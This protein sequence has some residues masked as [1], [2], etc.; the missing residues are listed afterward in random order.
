MDSGGWGLIQSNPGDNWYG[1]ANPKY[2][3]LAQYT[4]HIR[5]GMNIINSTGIN[6]V[7]AYD[8]VGRKLVIVTMNYGTAQTI[9]YNQTNFHKASGPVRCWT[10]SP[11][12]DLAR[13]GALYQESSGIVISNQTFSVSFPTNTIKTF[14]IQN[15]ENATVTLANLTRTYTGSAISASASTVP[16]GLTVNPIYNGSPTAPTNVGS[17]IV[18]GTIG[19][20]NYSGSATNTLAISPAQVAVSCR[21]TNGIFR[22]TWPATGWIPQSNGVNVTNLNIIPNPSRTSAFYRLRA[23]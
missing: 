17:Y 12:P 23:P 13:S 20:Q 2:Y 3:V 8:P 11:G 7:A 14:E 15:A 4:R 6:T 5:P 21:V 9:S 1:G 10:T 19:N 16:S 18:V 22:L